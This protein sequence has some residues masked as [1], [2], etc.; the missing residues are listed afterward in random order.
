[1]AKRGTL[2][3][4]FTLMDD[5]KLILDFLDYLFEIRNLSEN[6]VK[7][8]RID[9]DLL[10]GFASRRGKSMLSIDREDAKAMVKMLGED[11][12]EKAVH[13]KLS[14]YRSFYHYLQKSSKVEIDPFSFISLRYKVRE[15]PSILT[16]EEVMDLLALPRTDFLEERDHILFLFLYATGARISEALSVDVGDIEFAQRRI[17]IVGKGNKIRYLFFTKSVKRELEEYLLEREAYL[18]E[19]NSAIET[20]LF[21]SKGGKRLPFSSAHIIFDKYRSLLGW[22]KEFTPHTLRHCFATHLL[23]NGADIRFVQE[24]LGHT[25]I[26]T[27]Q[28]YTHISKT[29]L[30]G[31]YTKTHPHAKEQ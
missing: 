18:K 31:V 20:A 2:L 29:K 23:D 14:C 19:H 28:I 13:R 11:F 9:L 22:Q 7:N 4:L 17:R 15:L 24:V 21:I 8:Y 10:Q 5:D 26:S 12:S 16:K 30:K 6:T 25:N 3:I 1:M 27:T